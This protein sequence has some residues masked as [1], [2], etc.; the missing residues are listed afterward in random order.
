[1]HFVFRVIEETRASYLAVY[2]SPEAMYPW[3][4][5]LYLYR[6]L[7]QQGPRS[8]S[9]SRRRRSSSWCFLERPWP[10]GMVIGSGAFPWWR[11]D[12]AAGSRLSS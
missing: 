12:L 8:G 5:D 1:M 10:G 2:A 4:A 11:G 6:P 7:L 3:G 9:H